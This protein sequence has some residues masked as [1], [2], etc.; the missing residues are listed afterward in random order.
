MLQI[1][2]RWRS[3]TQTTQLLC[4]HTSNQQLVACKVPKQINREIERRFAVARHD[5]SIERKCVFMI[6]QILV[7]IQ[8]QLASLERTVHTI[9][10]HR[11]QKDSRNLHGSD[12]VL[13][14]K[15]YTHAKQIN[16][17]LFFSSETGITFWKRSNSI[18]IQG[19]DQGLYIQLVC[20]HIKRARKVQKSIGSPLY[21]Y[22]SYI[23]TTEEQ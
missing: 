17:F 18:Q 15:I 19:A 16:F 7:Y 4:Q 3:I 20:V 21:I 12:P 14:C 23:T 2:E 9:F 10:F 22:N 1:K 11:S 5:E 13:S 6:P 8:S